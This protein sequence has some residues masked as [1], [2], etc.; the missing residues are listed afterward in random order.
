MK[1]TYIIAIVALV[2]AVVSAEDS[3]SVKS[4][5]SDGPVTGFFNDFFEG[6]K[7]SENSRKNAVSQDE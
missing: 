6:G 1:F 7:V 5:G 3:Q 2:A 4:V